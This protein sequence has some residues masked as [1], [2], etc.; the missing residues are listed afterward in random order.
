[1]VA[2][3]LLCALLCLGA[4]FQP[5]AAAQPWPTNGWEVATPAEMGM[6]QSALEQAR[7]YALTGGGAGY[8]TRG[9]KLVMSWGDPVLRYGLKSASKS[10]GVTA[11]GL[12]L[13]D[14]LVSMTLPAK[15]Y[16]PDLGIPPDSNA[17]TGW[18]DM[19]TV[20]QLATHTAGFEKQGGYGDLIFA[21]G[22]TW[23]YSDG[24]ANWLADVLTVTYGQDLKTVLFDRVF[25]PLGIAPSDITW[26]NNAVRSDTIDGIKRREFASG[27]SANVDAMA[28]IGYLYLR[29]GVWDTEQIIPK[30]FVDEAST[31]VPAVAGLPVNLAYTYFNASDH[32]GLLWWNN[33]DGTLP[34]VPTDAFWAW[35]LGEKLIVV[36]PSLDIVAVRAGNAWQPNF[37]GDYSVLDPFITPIAMSILSTT[38]GDLTAD[39][40][41]DVRDILRGQQIVLGNVVPDWG[42]TVRGDVAPLVGGIPTPDGV[43]DLGDLVV[44]T[45]KVL[46]IRTF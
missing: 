34:N 11:L 23:S 26:R 38:K 31:S 19:I 37:S 27:I 40:V 18:L 36:I 8:I 30:S 3:L 46:G 42:E 29:G 33:A 2:L 24:G 44:I 41:V 7:D 9:G 22:S 10:V 32:Y 21:P 39:G 13:K 1:L 5:V 12:A 16:L 20:L 45:A 28:K 15:L 25:T 35:G 6:D 43:F 4:A 17:T 14:G